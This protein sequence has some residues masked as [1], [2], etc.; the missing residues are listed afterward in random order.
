MDDKKEPRPDP[1]A[2][3]EVFF[4]TDLPFSTFEEKRKERLRYALLQ[5]ATVIWIHMRGNTFVCPFEMADAVDE[6]MQL[7]DEIKKRTE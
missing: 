2:P 7:L 5:S 3:G 1:F 4:H 6:A